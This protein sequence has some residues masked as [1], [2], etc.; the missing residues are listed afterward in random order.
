M[1]LRQILTSAGLLP[2]AKRSPPTL[3]LISFAPIEEPLPWPSMSEVIGVL[4]AGRFFDRLKYQCRLLQASAARRMFLGYLSR[5][6]LWRSLFMANHRCFYVPFRLYLDRR[7]SQKQR[8]SQCATDLQVAQEKFGLANV[9]QLVEGHRVR[10]TEQAYCSV[11]LELNRI[12]LHEGFWALSLKDHHGKPLFNIS[13]GFLS[14]N[15][16]L[17]A[18]VQG[19][20]GVTGCNLEAIQS[21]TKQSHGLRPHHLL[22]NIFQMACTVWGITEIRGIDPEHQVK[23]R[24]NTDKQ[25][26]TFDYR[27]FWTELGATLLVDHD[28]RLPSQP[29]RR[30][31][32]EIPSR[33]RALYRKRYA[34]LDD[35]AT[36]VVTNLLDRSCN[37]SAATATAITSG[38]LPSMPATPIGQ[39]TC[40]SSSTL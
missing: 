38:S 6:G 21:I 26:F 30:A 33:K 22:L 1:Y 35:V 9:Q 13:F 31:A 36:G 10:L 14:H 17:I 18:S 34:W 19:V 29:Q 32:D 7:W 2:G 5:N 27:E 12:S 40:A 37:N 4:R 24:R 28:W 16:V 25:G 11:D 23:K 15:T 3:H 20:R 39:V 8:F